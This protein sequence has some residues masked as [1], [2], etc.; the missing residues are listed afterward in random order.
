M[1]F[2]D[3]LPLA[4]GVGTTARRTMPVA[5][6]AASTWYFWDGRKDSPMSAPFV[7]GPTWMTPPEEE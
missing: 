3:G 6:M 7:T 2:Q 5:G 1:R 4:R